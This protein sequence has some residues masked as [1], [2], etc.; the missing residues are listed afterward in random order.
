MQSSPLPCYLVPRRPKCLPQHP[1]L[2]HPQ[3]TFIPQCQHQVSSQPHKTRGKIM[4]LRHNRT[5]RQEIPCF[6]KTYMVH[7]HVHKSLSLDPV[8]NQLGQLHLLRHTFLIQPP[9][10]VPTHNTRNNSERNSTYRELRSRIRHALKH[11]CRLVFRHYLPKSLGNSDIRHSRF[12][13]ADWRKGN[14]I[15]KPSNSFSSV[16]QQPQKC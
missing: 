9:L 10:P 11:S 14:E 1:I 12:K 16:S 7:R 4:V 15:I 6:Y 13:P 2:R 5:Y 3:P 8:L